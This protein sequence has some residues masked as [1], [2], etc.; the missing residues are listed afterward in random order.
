VLRSYLET[1]VVSCWGIG[2]FVSYGVIFGLTGW[3]S[4]WAYRIPFAIQW[5]W[6]VI[7]VP[8]AV[9]C[10][11]SPWWLVRKTHL[12][13][14]EKSVRRLTSA[15][16]KEIAAESSK[17]A[18]ALMIET[19]R[20]EQEVSAGTSYLSCFKGSDL[21]RTEIACFAWGSQILTGF[22]IQSYATY[23]FQQAGLSSSDSF[24]MTLG[25][26]A[27]HLVCSK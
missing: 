18:V 26:G 21:W 19:N 14:A 12:E 11:E 10:P 6:P 2:Q 13:R 22:V 24:K 16:E 27:I 25:M 4:E 7:I 17:K 8:I 5:V 3:D 23:F 15:R 9:F 20:L 1:W